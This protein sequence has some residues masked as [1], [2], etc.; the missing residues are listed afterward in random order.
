MCTSSAF[1]G[2]STAIEKGPTHL[3]Q[4]LGPIEMRRAW[5]KRIVIGVDDPV[6]TGS[7]IGRNISEIVGR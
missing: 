5:F 2:S 3:S 6:K 4:C 7:S 1:S